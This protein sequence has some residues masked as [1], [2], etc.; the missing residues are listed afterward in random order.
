MDNP[1]TELIT[2]EKL[3][4][5]G[6]GLARTPDRVTMV[7][8]VLPGE[9]V[10]IAPGKVHAG[11]REARMAELV[12]PSPD[13]LEAPCPHFGTCGG[14]HYQHMSYPAQLQAKRDILREQL[15]RIGK[16]TV[17]G[18]IGILS[19]EPYG[20][21]N[22]I[23]L[24]LDRARL[25]YREGGSHKLVPI[26]ACP[27]ASPKL[28]EAVAAIRERIHHP[29][30]PKFIREIELFS[31]EQEVQFNVVHS[32]EGVSKHFFDWMSEVL[33]GADQP[34]LEY[35]VG[36]DRFV[37]SYQSFFQVNRFLINDLVKLVLAGAEG[38]YALD[39]YAGVGLFSL[40]L[41]RL[42]PRVTAVEVVR[43][44]AR[45]LEQ[46]A[47]GAPI[48]VVQMPT[49]EY[50]AK[51]KQ[52]PDFVLADPPRAGLGKPAV[53]DLVRLKPAHITLVSCDPATLARD[54]AG[55]IAG[56]Y[57]IQEVTMV[58]LFPQTFHLESVV[59]LQLR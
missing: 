52:T 47:R 32:E 12:T 45:D 8:Y 28:N 14:C 31:N 55:L 38:K 2:I 57:G 59:R 11:F 44:A 17:E 36:K 22:R 21:R 29:R 34:A 27:I 1:T 26:K 16:I 3:V 48:D 56:G 43:G 13:R 6:A 9:Q 39:L 33:P 50:L 54:L 58:D 42:L 35:R 25:G 18:E 37:V 51:L 23:Q 20:Y 41:S 53:A 30:F 19:G 15:Q 24:H 4:Y 40:P 10:R 7:P 49:E 5:G 46:N